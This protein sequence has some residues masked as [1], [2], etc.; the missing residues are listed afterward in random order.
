MNVLLSSLQGLVAMSASPALDARKAL[1]FPSPSQPS[2]GD[3]DDAALHQLME[4]YERPSAP[5]RQ[6]SGGDEL[7]D[8]GD[9]I[10]ADLI[11]LVDGF[12]QQEAA[13]TQKR[14]PDLEERHREQPH[15]EQA[16]APES[17]KRRRTQEVD[18]GVVAS[19]VTLALLDA[20]LEVLALTRRMESRLERLETASTTQ[21]G[22][23]LLRVA[24][25]QAALRLAEER[26]AAR[27]DEC[28]QL[29]AQLQVVRARLERAMA[30]SADAT[31]RIESAARTLEQHLDA[32]L[33][34][35]ALLAALK[36]SVVRPVHEVATALPVLGDEEEEED[37]DNDADDALCDLAQL[38]E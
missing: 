1:Y 11:R 4:A 14:S 18:S 9:D 34:H 37:D 20:Q 16:L 28:A 8:A 2:R 3:S 19:P 24:E 21:S 25:A 32:L 23:A 33:P 13:S 29:R 17:A 12:H 38:V 36:A 27:D 10:D 5:A 22:D 6:R 31:A 35:P 26:L 15:E 30:E 7:Y